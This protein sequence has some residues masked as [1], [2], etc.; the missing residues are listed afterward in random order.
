M[1]FVS[2][3]KNAKALGQKGGLKNLWRSTS[4][5]QKPSGVLYIVY[6]EPMECMRHM[7][8]SAFLTLYWS[9]LDNAIFYAV[10]Q[11]QEF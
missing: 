9:I 3:T 5:R 6:R 4:P 10:R 11:K 7:F 1:C 2:C 8:L